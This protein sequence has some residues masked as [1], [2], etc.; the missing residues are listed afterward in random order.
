M[1]LLVAA[2]RGASDTLPENTVVA[3]ADAIELG[4]DYVEFDVRA[5]GDGRLVLMHDERLE[6]TTDGAGR[7]ADKSLHQVRELDA[8]AWMGEAHRG[9]KVPTLNE[10]LAVLRGTGRFIVD[11]KETRAD[12]RE[13]L[14]LSLRADDVLDKAYV[15]SPSALVLEELARSAPDLQLAVPLRLVFSGAEPVALER[16]K[17]RMFLARAA[18]VSE[19]A[20]AAARSSGVPLLV[21]LP[22]DL[23]APASLSLAARLERL[24]A[25]GVLTARA[26]IFLQKGL[27]IL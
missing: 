19:E 22:R 3:V 10:T 14:V 2:H 13:E 12:L 11:F 18:D 1:A 8:G 9:R 23:D 7:L 15:S 27:R 5:T 17:P 24:G 21:T 16:L 26:R 20:A 6:R 4:C 25:S